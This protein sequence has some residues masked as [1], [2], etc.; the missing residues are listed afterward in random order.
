MTKSPDI[1]KYKYSGYGIGFDRHVEFSF[2]NGLGRN[3]IVFGADLSSFSY[4]NNNKNNILVFGKDFVLGIAGTTIYAEGLYKIN[5]AENNK[6]LCLPL[7]DNGANSFYLLMV[8]RFI[9]LKQK[10]LRLCQ[11]HYV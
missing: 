4:D 6:K 2:G 11:V 7:H 3:Y 8:Q 5:F 9:N 10:T 1:D